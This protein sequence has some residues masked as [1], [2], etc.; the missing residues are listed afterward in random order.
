MFN[1]WRGVAEPLAPTQLYTTDIIKY[2]NIINP[3]NPIDRIIHI[4]LI[5]PIII[6]PYIEPCDKTSMISLNYYASSSLYD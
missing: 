6:I 1:S 5:N 4:N 3:I 2:I